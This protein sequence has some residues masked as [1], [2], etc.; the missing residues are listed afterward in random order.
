MWVWV[1]NHYIPRI[2]VYYCIMY[3]TLYLHDIMIKLN[4]DYKSALTRILL[5]H[6]HRA[7]IQRIARFHSNENEQ[8]EEEEAKNDK[9]SS[10]IENQL[11]CECVSCTCALNMLYNSHLH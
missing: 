7:R 8:E 3:Y 11:L 2:T 9:Q 5:T 1:P 10:D 4:F 6:A